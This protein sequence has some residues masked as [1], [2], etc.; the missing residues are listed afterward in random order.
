[1]RKALLM[2]IL[3]GVV[4]LLW[5]PPKAEAQDPVTIALLA[6]IAIKVAQVAA[7]YV[8]R[9]LANAGRGCVLAGLDM[10]HIFLLPI[11]FFE[12]TFGAPFGFFKDGVRDMIVG[13][14]A[15]FS[16]CFHVI[17]IPVRLFGVF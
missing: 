17:T 12:I 10:I 3:A 8:M 5:P 13:S 6:P 15:P 2:T 4:F 16:L 1:M 7:P 11:G 9:G 14:I